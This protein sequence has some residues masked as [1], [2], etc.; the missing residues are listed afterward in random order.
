MKNR[1]L[2]YILMITINLLP[3]LPM[4]I[5]GVTGLAFICVSS[6]RNGLKDGMRTA[7]L[8]IL[9][10]TMCVFL[11]INVDYKY[12]FASML[13][14]TAA[15]I[16]TAYFIGG[17]TDKLVKRNEQLIHEIEI[18][19][20]AEV[21]LKEKIEILQSLMSA[22]PTPI[23]IKGLDGRYL[24]CNDAF[25]QW[26]GCN[27]EELP[28][29]NVFD[30]M[31]VDQAKVFNS[32]DL[33]LLT[34]QTPQKLET[35]ATFQDGTIRNVICCKAVIAGDQGLPSGIVVV[36]HDITDQK[37]REQLKLNIIEEELIIDEM[38]KYDRIKTEFFMNI[39]HELRTPLN[40]IL[41]AIQLMELQLVNSGTAHADKLRKNIMSI[42]QN[43]LRLLRL[44]N[45]LL[46]VS[47][48]EEHS[49]EIR[50]R[51][52]NIVCLVEEIVQSVTDYANIKGIQIEFDTEFEERLI[53]CDEEKVERI[54]LNLLSNAIKFTPDGGHIFVNIRA[55]GDFVCIRVKDTGIGIPVEKQRQLFQRFCQVRPI[56]TRTHEG[57]GIGL[58]LVKSLTE[59]H[60]GTVTVESAEG[61]GTTFSVFLP[62]KVLEDHELY[63]ANTAVNRMSFEKIQLEFSDIYSSSESMIC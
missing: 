47:K 35:V 21:E 28:G 36:I 42:K 33:E 40:V 49:S 4:S 34:K 45:N 7:G 26:F 1:Y 12:V 60:G 25:G 58:C 46:D 29:K 44:V 13:L 17:N 19:K 48:I 53:S 5:K 56:L 8:L 18:R 3:V 15:Y 32:M 30:L 31:E 41:G 63:P 57:S 6:V 38:K 39:S 22:I 14:G 43:S 51:N 16:G 61:S 52:W 55:Q 50:C 27:E 23:C 2:F 59:L 11:G 24:R 54:M 20:K 9:L 37:E 10:N 62:G